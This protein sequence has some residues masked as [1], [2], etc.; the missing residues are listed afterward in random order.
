MASYF[1][2][3]SHDV[4]SSTHHSLLDMQNYM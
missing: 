2:H 1:Q 4:E 3:G